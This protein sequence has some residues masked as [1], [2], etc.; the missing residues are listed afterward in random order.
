MKTSPRRRLPQLLILALVASF[1]FTST[2]G[3]RPT[4]AVQ[5]SEADQAIAKADNALIVAQKKRIQA[6]TSLA[7][8]Q[9]SIAFEDPDQDAITS[10]LRLTD[11]E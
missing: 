1:I 10:M 8:L 3:T 7:K 6:A 9:E 5:Q 4:S 11:I 2:L